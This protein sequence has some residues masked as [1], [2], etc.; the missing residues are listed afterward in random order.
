MSNVQTVYEAKR[1]CG[2]RS[3]G[4]DGVGVYL[5]GIGV[6]D[7]CHR[8]PFP[9]T[10]CG[11]C[12][13][14]IKQSRGFTWIA[15]ERLFAPDVEP[16]CS[17][18]CKCY[19]NPFGAITK[20]RWPQMAGLMWVGAKYYTPEKFIREAETM[21]ISKKVATVPIGFELG[22]DIIYM[23]HPKAVRDWLDTENPYKPGVFMVF[24]PTHVDLVVDSP[25]NIPSKANH[26]INIHGDKAQLVQVKKLEDSQGV[27]V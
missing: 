10:V 5:R 8:L 1:G 22:K 23:A 17:I 11:C 25:E 21:G 16:T 6:F 19:L 26:L 12:G 18:K 3:P 13:Q 27:L 9:L 24:K 7:P 15:P 4:A 20:D 2:W 14:G